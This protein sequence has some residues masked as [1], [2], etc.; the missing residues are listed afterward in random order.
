MALPI[1]TISKSC[2]LPFTTLKYIRDRPQ[3]LVPGH[4]DPGL[5]KVSEPALQITF[6]RKPKN[7]ELGYL[8]GGDR[9]LCDILLG[10]PDDSISHRMF[11][12]SFNQYNEV[13]SRM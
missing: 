1:Y 5:A 9:E 11:A 2:A 4:D 10:C 13:L 3:E 12:I 7:P 6:S 8:L